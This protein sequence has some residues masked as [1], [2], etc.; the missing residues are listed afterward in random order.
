MPNPALA[1][2]KTSVR[3]ECSR[4]VYPDR[5][6][7]H[8]TVSLTRRERV[9]AVLTGA[10]NEDKP[11]ADTA[12][13]HPLEGPQGD[14]LREVLREADAE[15][16]DAPADHVARQGAAHLVPLQQDVGRE[17]EAH[18]RDVE[19]G[20]QPCVLLAREVGVVTE[21]E[22]GLGAE[23]CLVRLLDA[24]A[25]PHQRQE[26]AVG[27]LLEGLVFLLGELVWLE[28]WRFYQYIQSSAGLIRCDQVP[29]SS[30]TLASGVLFSLS[31]ATCFSVSLCFSSY[32]PPA[33][34]TSISAGMS[35]NS[36]TVVILG[37]FNRQS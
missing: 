9:D 29:C 37:C 5:C 20:R 36:E 32:L 33:R 4:V 23:G 30:I 19:G 11:Q 25:E 21:A 22:C 15:D 31:L 13:E 24:V 2:W 7:L 35:V 28:P 27:F 6:Q 10:N 18:V 1:L 17:L 34:M 26:V 16:D 3:D 12:L 14:K 8:D